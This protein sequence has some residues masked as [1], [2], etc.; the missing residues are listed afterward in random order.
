[1]AAPSACSLTFEVRRGPTA[2]PNGAA[3][4]HSVPPH[5][6]L[7]PIITRSRS[8]SPRR[9]TRGMNPHRSNPWRENKAM[10]G[11]FDAKIVTANDQMSDA[12]R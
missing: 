5:G 6:N 8:M 9:V 10:L 4:W 2:C 3:Q 12:P 7:R 11:W 1:M